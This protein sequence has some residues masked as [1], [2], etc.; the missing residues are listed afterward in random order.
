MK[1]KEKTKCSKC[2]KLCSS[3]YGPMLDLCRLCFDK[4]KFVTR[5]PNGP[6]I[7]EE[8]LTEHTTAYFTLTKTQKRLVSKR[9]DEKYPDRNKYNEL[10]KLSMYVRELIV[11]DIK[12]E[13]D[14][15]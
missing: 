13:D 7:Y 12:E 9:L 5:I 4:S 1:L 10:N 11:K 2:G 3:I 8:E 6:M 15:L 14:V